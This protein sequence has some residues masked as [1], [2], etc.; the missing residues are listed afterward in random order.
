MSTAARSPL[1][2]DVP[3]TVEAGFPGSDYTFWV[4]LIVPAATSPAVVGSLNDEAARAL[5]NP[6]VKERLARLGADAWVL[7]PEAF[8]AH[9]RTEMDVAARIAKAANLKAQ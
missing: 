6:E 2:P 8:N 5:A 9:I 7:S 4:G 3:T 1:L